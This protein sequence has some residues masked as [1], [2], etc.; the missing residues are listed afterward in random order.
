[1]PSTYT[2]SGIGTNDPGGA[3][4]QYRIPQALLPIDTDPA[5]ASTF[6]PGYKAL[7]DWIDWL[8]IP[9]A[10]NFQ[11]AE[12]VQRWRTAAGQV[13]FAI[14]HLGFPAG[15][16]ICR[17]F[18]WCSGPGVLNGGL[19]STTPSTS[20]DV[21]LSTD[22]SWRAQTRVG[23]LGGSSVIELDHMPHGGNF[24]SHA[25]VFLQA[26]NGVGDYSL[27][28]QGPHASFE[29]GNHIA[30]EVRVTI[31]A[32]YSEMTSWVGIGER[33]TMNSSLG[34]SSI[35]D[36]IGFRK[37]GG[38]NWMCVTR[39]GGVET[40]SD[41]GIPVP[42]INTGTS[43]LRVEWNGANVV[44]GGGNSAVNFFINGALIIRHTSNLPVNKKVSIILGTS[45]TS[46]VNDHGG[47]FVGPGKFRASLASSGSDHL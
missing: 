36:F 2:G 43:R 32:S 15:Q 23:S 3:P 9:R 4:A 17:D 21:V 45:N 11:W 25:L 22:P 29:A 27:L 38:P 30:L 5:N 12:A 39:V 31:T 10:R 35:N 1:M 7:A 37:D 40:Q 13:R 42:N 8:R 34:M 19:I 20:Q 46:G 16:M 18:S 24:G 6:L 47:I 28:T 26:A 14:D 44:D 33:V 41:S